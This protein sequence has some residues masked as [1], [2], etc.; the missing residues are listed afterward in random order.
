MGI[1]QFIGSIPPPIVELMPSVFRVRRA[2]PTRVKRPTQDHMARKWE[3]RLQA[4]LTQEPSSS[5]LWDMIGDGHSD[6]PQKQKPH[7]S[8]GPLKVE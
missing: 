3:S 6:Q 7:D 8:N 5:P 1:H 2:G 4:C